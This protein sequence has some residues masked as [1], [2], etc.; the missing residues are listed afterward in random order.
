MNLTFLDVNLALSL[1]TRRVVGTYNPESGMVAILYSGECY[2]FPAL[3]AEDFRAALVRAFWLTDNEQGA[4]GLFVRTL[5]NLSRYVASVT[6]GAYPVSKTR[7][8]TLRAIVEK[9]AK[10]TFPSPTGRK[11]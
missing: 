6:S 7:I 11:W 1:G 5:N 8:A 2:S 4:K 9:Q 3:K 10:G